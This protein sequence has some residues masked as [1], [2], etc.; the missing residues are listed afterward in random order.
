[1]WSHWPDRLPVLSSTSIGLEPG[2]R[3]WLKLGFVARPGVRLVLC[4]IVALLAT[5]SFWPVATAFLV[6]GS[7]YDGNST[8]TCGTNAQNGW[9]IL[10]SCCAGFFCS[11]VSSKYEPDGGLR[12]TTTS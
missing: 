5:S 2:E 8:E 1:E 10:T 4:G 3:S 9:S 12:N 6:F 11:S 7:Q